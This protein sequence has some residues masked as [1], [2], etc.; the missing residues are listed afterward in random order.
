MNSVDHHESRRPFS[1]R[2]FLADGSPSGLKLIEKTGWTG[3]GIVCPRPRFAA[4]KIRKEFDQAGVYVLLGP[5]ETSDIPLVYVGEADPVRKRLECHHSDKDFWTVA[6]CFTSKDANLN[7]AHVQWLEHKLLVLARDA[8]R[9][10]LDNGNNP[11][12][13]SLSEPDVADVN[14]FLEEM[15]LCF[16]VLGVTI[17]EKPANKPKTKTLL[18]LRNKGLEAQG[19]ESDDGFVVKKGSTAIGTEVP[20]IQS[21]IAALRRDLLQ[22]GILVRQGDHLILTQDYEFTSPSTAAS[23]LLAASNNGRDS[24]RTHSG[25]PLK[26]LQAVDAA[27][28]GCG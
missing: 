27:A 23:A 17:F 21:Y 6:Y 19:Y 22:S 1:M 12:A 20:S 2:I 14:A 26:E 18:L 9:C 28:D 3:L 10:K 25:V 8:K 24:W 16:P 15:L 13:P 5:S 4:A 7:K 11:T